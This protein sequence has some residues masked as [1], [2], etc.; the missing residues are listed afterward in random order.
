MQVSS[1]FSSASVVPYFYNVKENESYYLVG[2]ESMHGRWGDFGGKKE[3]EDTR[4]STTAMRE[5]TEE[6]I[7]AFPLVREN[8]SL[9]L[10]GTIKIQVDMHVLYVTTLSVGKTHP[11]NPKEQLNFKQACNVRQLHSQ[12][13]KQQGLKNCQKEKTE[14]AWIKGSELLSNLNTP[15]NGKAWTNNFSL[16]EAPEQTAPKIL[17]QPIRGCMGD[18]FCKIKDSSTDFDLQIQTGFL[19][20][21]GS[22]IKI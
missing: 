14:L 11:Q 7:G 2:K 17:G 8:I 9:N 19:N 1:K 4:P 18:A 15:S 13:L 6:T 21:H 20:L 10:K 16:Y 22:Q 3:N 12:N 5:F